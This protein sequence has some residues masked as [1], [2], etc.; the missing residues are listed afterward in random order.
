MILHLAEDEK[1]INGAISLFETV[2]PGNN[3]FIIY[4]FNS[5]NRLK[6]VNGLT[7][8]VTSVV[9]MKDYFKAIGDIDQYQAVILHS[10]TNEKLLLVDKYKNSKTHFAWVMWGADLYNYLSTKGYKL[11]LWKPAIWKFRL[12]WQFYDPLNLFIRSIYANLR[13]RKSRKGLY[14]SVL[15]RINFCLTTNLADFRLFK[16]YT[17]TKAKGE[18][19]SYYSIDAVLGE[20]LINRKVNS[21]NIIIGNSGSVTGNHV[22]AY[23]LLKKFNL[24]GRK[25]VV[26]L[27]YGHFRYRQLLEKKGRQILG[28]NFHPLKD[29]MPLGEYNNILCS[30]NIVIMPQ[31]RQEA[32][33]NVLISLYLGA[34][35]YLFEE[36][37]LFEY[38]T[39]I[40][41]KVFSIK[42]DL[43]PDNPEALTSLP[44]EIQ[45]QNRVILMKDFSQEAIIA[46][47]KTML[48]D[49]IKQ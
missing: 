34:K 7:T 12:R 24:T 20:H 16:K 4:N 15:S 38:F 18:W 8:V 9:G 27:S 48:Q 33:G 22:V 47:T 44:E 10:L 43:R 2:Q 36:N 41:V 42:K 14:D 3:K 19:F 31:I 17:D 29:F 25:V 1:V 40:G 32:F 39:S 23:Q 30:A 5:D 35:V 11:Y 26:P 13:G 6:H 45:L 37:N 21:D 28:E 46:N 49:I